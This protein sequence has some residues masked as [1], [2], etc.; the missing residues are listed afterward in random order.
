MCVYLSCH[1]AGLPVG[2]GVIHGSPDLL[3]LL[4]QFNCCLNQHCSEPLTEVLHTHT[5]THTLRNEERNLSG[6]TIR[7][8][9]VDCSKHHCVFSA[10]L[11]NNNCG[12]YLYLCNIRPYCGVRFPVAPISHTH[13]Q[14]H[15][16]PM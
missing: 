8:D 16:L 13:I 11:Q 15:G 4:I 9:M 2:F 7:L 6:H 1:F 10:A 5:Q 3:H 14:E 12:Y